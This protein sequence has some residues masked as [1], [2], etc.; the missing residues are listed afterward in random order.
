[1]NSGARVILAFWA[2]LAVLALALPGCTGDDDPV[3]DTG[4]VCTSDANCDDGVFCNGA[5]VC[6]TGGSCQPGPAP[7]LG[8]DVCDEVN[9]VCVAPDIS[10]VSGDA[11]RGVPNTTLAQPFV[12]E[13]LDAN[14]DPVA[15]A[16]VSG[17]WSRGSASGSCTTGGDGSCTV[18][19]SENSTW[20]SSVS[21]T[22]NDIVGSTYAANGNHDP[23]SDSNGTSITIS[24]P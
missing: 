20:R 16:N 7:C 12:V 3:V 13:V 15:G 18:T 5:E 10:I 2:G 21:Y 23:E 6:D 1:M 24:R 22:V 4:M 8:G 11:Q 9:D 17:D 19:S 14:N